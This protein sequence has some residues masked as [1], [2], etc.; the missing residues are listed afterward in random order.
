MV[1]VSRG[2]AHVVQSIEIECIP[3]KSCPLMMELMTTKRI[4]GMTDFVK[5]SHCGF[6]EWSQ[7]KVWCSKLD[8]CKTPDGRNESFSPV[9]KKASVPY[10]Q[11]ENC[12]DRSPRSRQLV[13]SQ[14]C[15]GLGNGVDSCNGDSGG[16]LMQEEYSNSEFVT[17]VMGVISYGFGECGTG[18]SVNTYVPYYTDWIKE[19]IK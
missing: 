14:V 10:V 16:P 4:F 8:F 15:V 3:L 9:L 6:D 2:T 11:T 5:N 19:N 1:E 18:P 17:Y 12:N 7:P 13:E